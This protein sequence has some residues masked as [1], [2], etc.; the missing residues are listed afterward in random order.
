[1]PLINPGMD[2]DLVG[3]LIP[4]FNLALH[5]NALISGSVDWFLYACSL[6]STVIYCLIAVYIT[7]IMFDDENIRNYLAEDR[8]NFVT[9]LNGN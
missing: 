9:K 2:L 4:C 5:T 3:S 1:M 8:M 6:G 7:Y